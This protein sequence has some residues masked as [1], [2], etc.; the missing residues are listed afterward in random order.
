LNRDENNSPKVTTFGGVKRARISSQS[1]KRSIRETLKN[2]SPE[3]FSGIRTRY[4]VPLF[5]EELLAAGFNEKNAN[6]LS[7]VGTTCYSVLDPKDKKRTKTIMYLDKSEVQEII[8]QWKADAVIKEWLAS[9]KSSIW[10]NLIC[11]SSLKDSFAKIDDKKCLYKYKAGKKNIETTLD[12]SYFNKFL[13]RIPLKEGI[14]IKLFG[15]FMSSNDSLTV[16]SSTSF[17]HAFSTHAVHMESDFFAAVDERLPPTNSGAAITNTTEYNTATYYKFVSLNISDF[18]DSDLSCNFSDEEKRKIISMFIHAVLF[19]IP[20]AK[21]SS[22][23]AGTFPSYI[24]GC[25]RDKSSSVNFANA[26]EIPINISEYERSE[27]KS[28]INLS[29]T[30][31]RNY[32]AKTHKMGWFAFSDIKTE[33]ELSEISFTEKTPAK[34]VNTVIEFINELVANV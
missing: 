12:L 7:I 21:K 1:L 4:L 6:I 13:K 17:A 32:F 23:N 18:W 30:S 33:V 24:L 25:I 8:K 16:E 2:L 28:Y 3:Y 26:F 29:A 31:L 14:D 15:R 9:E 5:K 11:E 20:S 27:N 19:S 10:Y 22:M 34:K